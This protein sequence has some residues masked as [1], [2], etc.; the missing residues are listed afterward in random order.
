MVS[1]SAIQRTWGF[2]ALDN[3]VPVGRILVTPNLA[4]GKQGG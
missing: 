1:G 3:G 2:N 4:S